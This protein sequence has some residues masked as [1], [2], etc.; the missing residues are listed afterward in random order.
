MAISKPA[1]G[2]INT[3][4]SFDRFYLLF[5][6]NN[7]NRIT[8]EMKRIELVREIL[9]TKKKHRPFVII[10]RDGNTITTDGGEPITQQQLQEMESDQR[11]NLIIRDIIKKTDNN[12]R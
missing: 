2:K 6:F 1:I 10:I 9:R 12:E 5:I 7:Q 8:N 3:I 4:F 11:V